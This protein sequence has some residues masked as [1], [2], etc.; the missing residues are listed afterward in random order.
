MSEV[1]VGAVQTET[2]GRRFKDAMPPWPV[3]MLV[4]LAGFLIPAMLLRFPMEFI[5]GGVVGFV[6]LALVI[7]HPF[8]GLLVFLGLLYLRPEESFPSLAGARMAL[9]VSLA[10]LFAWV[11]N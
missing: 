5:V 6:G 11:V 4:V 2:L 7:A 1:I 9:T 10:A 3:S 8:L